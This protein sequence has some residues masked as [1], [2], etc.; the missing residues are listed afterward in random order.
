MNG[1]E[2]ICFKTVFVVAEGTDIP[3][4]LLLPRYQLQELCSEAAKLKNL[5]AMGSIPSDRLVR[6]L[7][8]LEKNIRAAEKMS[9]VGDPVSMIKFYKF[10]NNFWYN[11]SVLD[12][13][14]MIIMYVK[15]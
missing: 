9:I 4:E 6:L 5:G 12:L 1:D 7:N 3:E 13:Y 14:Q 8:L 2:M 11:F 15:K 10:L